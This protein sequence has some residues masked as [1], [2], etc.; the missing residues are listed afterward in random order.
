MPVSEFCFAYEKQYQS[1]QSPRDHSNITIN[2]KLIFKNSKFLSWICR[3]NLHVANLLLKA[4]QLWEALL[5][6]DPAPQVMQSHDLI[7][8]GPLTRSEW[9]VAEAR[10]FPFLQ[11]QMQT[12]FLASNPTEA[13]R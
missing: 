12:V 2:H 7:Q 1:I 13:K 11:S 8:Q 4:L 5:Q 10:S 6:P 9:P 3:E